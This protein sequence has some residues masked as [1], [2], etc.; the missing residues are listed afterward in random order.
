MTETQCERRGSNGRGR[1]GGRRT[2]SD[3]IGVVGAGE[4]CTDG[5]GLERVLDR[6]DGTLLR[7]KGRSATLLLKSDGD[8]ETH[9]ETTVKVRVRKVSET[10]GKEREKREARTNATRMNSPTMIM[11]QALTYM[12]LFCQVARFACDLAL[13]S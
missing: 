7:S 12:T 11:P 3:G 6:D 10:D 5:A 13:L 4:G 1:E 8:W 2:R 9:V